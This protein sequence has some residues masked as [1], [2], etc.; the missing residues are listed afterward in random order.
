MA[1][2]SLTTNGIENEQPDIVF[3]HCPIDSHK[4]HQAASLLT[5]QAWMRSKKKFRL[6][7]YEVCLGSQ[8]M[9]FHPSDYVDITQEQETKRKALFCHVSQNPSGIYACGHEVMEKFR[10]A[11]AG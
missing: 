11:E 3:A 9:T 8:T 5:I 6:Y 2:Q 1:I 4:D 7:F 10:G